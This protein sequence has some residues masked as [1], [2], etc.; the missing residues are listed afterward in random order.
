MPGLKRFVT[1]LLCIIASLP[2][3]LSAF[4]LGGRTLLRHSMQEKLAS[5]ELVCLELPGTALVWMEEGKELLVDGRMFDVRSI[6][7]AGDT[8]L[9][10]GLYDDNETTL[11]A[12]LTRSE[13]GR[14]Q[15]AGMIPA[16][17]QV[18]LGITAVTPPDIDPGICMAA[19]GDL[20]FGRSGQAS[21]RDGLRRIFT[22]PPEGR[23]S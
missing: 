19:T 16:L 1:I 7:Y 11:F 4:F 15:G 22:P 17:L 20:S 2:M 12:Q 18:C 8:C 23:L 10:S 9:L 3:F 5:R 21:V 6:R 14:R 13:E